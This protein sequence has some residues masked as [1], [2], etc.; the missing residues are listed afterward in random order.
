[1]F[2]WFQL[3]L[4]GIIWKA[5]EDFWKAQLGDAEDAIRE[6]LRSLMGGEQLGTS[7]LVKV[8]AVDNAADTITILVRGPINL[9][10]AVTP[11]MRVEVVISRGEIHLT[12]GGPPIRIKEW[13]TVIGDL[14]INR[15]QGS[16]EKAVSGS[17]S[18]VVEGSLGFGYDSGAWVGEGSLKVGVAPMRLGAAIYGGISDRGMVLGLDAEFPRAGAIPLGPTGLG[19]RGFGGDFAYNFIARLEKEGMPIVNPAAFDYVTWARD[20]LSID[21]WKPGPID[22]TAVGIGVR[23]VLCTMVDQGFIF[24]LNPVGFAFLTPGGAFILGGKGVLLRQKSFGIE[25]YF[26]VDFGSA[27]LAFGSGVNIEI[28]S[29]PEELLGGLSITTLKGSGQ[30]DVFF[31]FSNPTAWFFDFGREDKPVMLEVLT[32]VPVISMLFSEKAEAYLRINHHRIAF[33][34]GFSIGGTFKL[35]KILELTARLGA[36]LHGYM[37]RDPL[38][39][40]GKLDVLGELSFKVFDKFSFI[41]TGHAT[42]FVYLPT[43]VLF[44]FELSYKL[45]L[46]WPLPDPEGKKGFGDDEI[47]APAITSPLLAGS[48]IVN[49]TTTIQEQKITVSHTVSE[50]QWMPGADKLW[51]DLELVVPFARR[52]TDKTGTVTGIVPSF[53]ISVPGSYEVKEELTKLEILDLVHNTVVPNVKA[54][55]VNGP[56]GSTALLHVLGTDPFSWLTA[57]SSTANF[58]TSSPPRTRDV[59]FGFGPPETFALPRRFDDLFVTPVNDPAKL[60]LMFQPNLVNRVLRA[61]ELI[62]RFMS[63]GEEITVDQVVLFLVGFSQR[64]KLVIEP[65]NVEVSFSDGGE[66]V[67]RVRLV[68]ATFSFPTPRTHFS[69]R[70]QLGGDFLVH[71]VRYR[72]ATQEAGMAL[73]RTLLR[74]GRYRLTVEGKSTAVHPEFSA[75]P[76]LYPSAAPVDWQAMQ[77]FEVVYPETLHPYIYYSTFGDN[78][79]FSRDQHPWT[80]WTADT[81]DP[82]LF[83]FGLPLYR[84]YH[85]VVRFLV[86]YVSPMFNETPLKLRIVYEKGGEIVHTIAAMPAPDGKSSMLPESQTWITA[87]GGTV[88]TD[89]ELV[90]PELLSKPGTARL[91]LFFNHPMSDEVTLGDWTGIVSSFNNFREHL[92]WSGTCLTTYYTNAGRQ[93]RSACPSLGKPPKKPLFDYI[94]APGIE[95]LITDKNLVVVSKPAALVSLLEEEMVTGPVFVYPPELAAAPLDWLLPL[96]LAEHL[97]ELDNSAGLRFGRFAASSGVRFNDGPG[98][99]LY[100]ISEPVQATTIEAVTDNQHRVC[101]LWVRTPEPVDWRRVTVSL[102]IRHVEPEK[103]CPNSYARRHPLE[104]G[105]S[106]LPSPDGTSAF[107]IGTFAG[108]AILLPRGEFTLT[109]KFN[110]AKAGLPPLRPSVF[111]G[112]GSELVTLRFLQPL[113]KSWPQPSD[114]LV[115]PNYIVQVALKYLKFPP[116]LFVEAYQKKLN[117]AEFEHRILSHLQSVDAALHAPDETGLESLESRELEGGKA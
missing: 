34:A 115:I 87:M 48:F 17:S 23:T 37:G 15:D 44:R 111:V 75:H 64:N 106:M 47:I 13:R 53:S 93:R 85:L 89:Q 5:F 71:G 55:W 36:S 50:R 7:P 57:Q 81:W 116:G 24:E 38:L 56:G 9:S 70:N 68:V 66:I 94:L 102:S 40:R 10:D 104:L 11:F 19:L 96:Q 77:E 58:A 100:G 99:A 97:G 88:P 35:K 113:G 39:I 60:V 4:L 21:R 62:L 105:V 41:L 95:P 110:P 22:K 16:G 12:G 86:P 29:P 103:D 69:V 61:K 98:D 67:G 32:D 114:G 31:S 79:R 92:T 6:K 14:A 109:L 3:L 90:F 1:M 65:E 83:G 33:G 42:V 2:P 8:L 80:T 59:F 27:S 63:G 84:Q 91:T 28:K 72:E 20:R 45:D 108:W 30:L 76:E 26:V 107:L 117:A 74:P 73:K 18:K 82:A 25:S 101:A 54:V 43:P 112:A 52:V 78:R 51:P 46:P 49:G